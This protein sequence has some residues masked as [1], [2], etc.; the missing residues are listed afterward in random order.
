[1]MYKLVERNTTD[2]YNYKRVDLLNYL[3][4]SSIKADLIAV[5]L[6]EINPALS[7]YY[8]DLAQAIGESCETVENAT[9]TTSIYQ[10]EKDS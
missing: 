8:S 5:D 6:E 7:K 4:M 10:T 9:L 3:S 1:M 2:K